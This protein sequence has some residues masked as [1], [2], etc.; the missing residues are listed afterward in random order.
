MTQT[1]LDAHLGRLHKL[2]AELDVELEQAVKEKRD[3][4]RY[5]L[6]QGRI[7]FEVPHPE[8]SQEI[9]AP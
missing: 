9:G 3:L 8:S 2:Q 4:F 5:S 1:K 7:R 6:E